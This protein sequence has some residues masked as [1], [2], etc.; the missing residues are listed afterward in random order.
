MTFIQSYKDHVNIGVKGVAK[1]IKSCLNIRIN[2][3]FIPP[4]SIDALTMII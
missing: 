4:K 2:S 1:S 3:K